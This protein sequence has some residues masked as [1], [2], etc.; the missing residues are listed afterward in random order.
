MPRKPTT[1]SSKIVYLCWS[2]RLLQDVRDATGRTVQE[3]AQRLRAWRNGYAFGW[4]KVNEGEQMR[5]G[6]E[7]EPVEREYSY[8]HVDV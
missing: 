5:L 2:A 6:V 1:M 4:F 7:R 3:R 8:G